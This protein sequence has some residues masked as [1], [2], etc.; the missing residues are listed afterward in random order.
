MEYGYPNKDGMER[1]HITTKGLPRRTGEQLEI[2][3]SD[4]REI[5]RWNGRVMGI[6]EQTFPHPKEW[7]LGAATETMDK[8]TVR[9]LTAVISAAKRIEPSCI[10]AW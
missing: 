4:M 1:A 10:G 7:R 3:F 8:L 9:S 5:V 6:A 2:D